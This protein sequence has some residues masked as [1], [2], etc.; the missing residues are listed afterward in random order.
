MKLNEITPELIDEM[1]DKHPL[2][3]VVKQKNI[4]KYDNI[5]GNIF[6]FHTF[7]GW[8]MF[9][10]NTLETTEKHFQKDLEN[11]NQKVLKTSKGNLYSFYSQ[12]TL[13]LFKKDK[14]FQGDLKPV[15]ISVD[16]SNGISQ[17]NHIGFLISNGVE[18]YIR[19]YVIPLVNGE[20]RVGHWEEKYFSNN[21]KVL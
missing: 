7:K 9:N 18:Y 10:K 16:F 4:L 21:E 17:T 14:G 15:Y 13:L 19:K 5:Y 12:N 8:L 20:M 11:D 1:L 3:G 6:R 2:R